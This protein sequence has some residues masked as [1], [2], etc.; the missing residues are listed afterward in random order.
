MIQGHCETHWK[1]TRIFTPVGLPS[2]PVGLP[3]AR[4]SYGGGN[5][6]TAAEDMRY[7]TLNKIQNDYKYQIALL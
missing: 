5:P 2:R 7:L 6:L 1:T 3:W 4:Q